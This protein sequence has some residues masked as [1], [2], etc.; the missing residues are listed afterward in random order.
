MD[1]A[2]FESGPGHGMGVNSATEF[3][4]TV[5]GAMRDRGKSLM[6]LNMEKRAEDAAAAK[7]APL[8]R[9]ACLGIGIGV[10]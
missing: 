5:T 3:T 10:H 6:E 8:S 9:L 7:C 4:G 2:G 1:N